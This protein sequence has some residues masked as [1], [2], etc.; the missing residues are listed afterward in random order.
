M[1]HQVLFLFY[2]RSYFF[3]FVN[4]SHKLFTFIQRFI[5]LSYPRVFSGGAS[6]DFFYL[7]MFKNLTAISTSLSVIVGRTRGDT[8][9]VNNT[10]KSSLFWLY[11]TLT[12][13]KSMFGI[14]HQS[15]TCPFPLS[16]LFTPLGND[17]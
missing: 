15:T 14:D 1:T 4:C 11:L 13:S 7:R 3:I 12:C 9:F 6:C 8:A 17:S 5:Y 2:F 10:T 16:C